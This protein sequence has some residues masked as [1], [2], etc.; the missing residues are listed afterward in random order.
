MSTNPPTGTDSSAANEQWNPPRGKI[1][2]RWGSGEPTRKGVGKRWVDP[3]HPDANS[4]RIDKGNPN[5]SQPSQQV[6][7]VIV[8]KDG[9]VIGRDGRPIQ[10]SIKNNAVNVHIPLQE[11]LRWR[12]WYEP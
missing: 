2:S 8:R 9:K 4:I 5:N 3:D 11:W 1:P 6:D 10:G 12:K 7:H